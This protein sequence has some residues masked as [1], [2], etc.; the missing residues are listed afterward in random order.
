MK[1][2]SNWQIYPTSFITGIFPSVLNT[3]KVVTVFKKDSK[4]DIATIA[5]SPCYQILIILKK[6]MYIR[7]YTFQNKNVI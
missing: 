1:F 5:H 4:L 7:L 6:R 2:R 3:V